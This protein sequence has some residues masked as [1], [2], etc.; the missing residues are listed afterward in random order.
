MAL[1]SQKDEMD[2]VPPLTCLY[3]LQPSL[4]RRLLDSTRHFL[5]CTHCG[6]RGPL[7]T[8]EDSP[9]QPAVTELELLQA[10][11]D[12]SPDIMFISTLD[13]TFLLCNQAL[14]RFYGAT[15]ER[16]KGRTEADF[17]PDQVQV[18]SHLEEM[19][20]LLRS[21]ETRVVDESWTCPKSGKT[22]H[23]QLIKKPLKGGDGKELLLVIGHDTTRRREMQQ[24]LEQT[25][26][27]L[28]VTNERLEQLVSERTLALE[29]A[30][31]E[32]KSMAFQ[33][34]LTGIGNRIMLDAW[35]NQQHPDAPI[36]VMM[37]DLDHFK[38]IND[39]FGH[40][41]GDQALVAV[42]DCLSANTRRDDLLVRWGGEE[43]LLILKNVK[44]E[45]ATRIAENLRQKIEQ[46]SLLPQEESMTVSIGLVACKVSEFDTA[47]AAADEA[48]YQAKKAGRNR[49]IT[50]AG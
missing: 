40:K 23:F 48:L 41:M 19:R 10:M 9:L 50:L 6:A 11:V 42:A 44:E 39:R 38:L 36:T 24:R 49:T 14:A 29:K 4:K 43:F 3:C 21:G 27:E 15:P 31:A 25:K 30:N 18:Q 5:E 26:R 2:N 37:L 7:V 16:V 46:I 35:L 47:M 8:L 20:A 13:G 32:L 1:W 34:P 17:N 22:H 12:E 45:Q 33:D 28:E